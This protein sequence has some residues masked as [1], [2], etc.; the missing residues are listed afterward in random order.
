MQNKLP[1]YIALLTFV[2]GMV[3]SYYLFPHYI[4]GQTHVVKDVVV[5][6]DTLI[7]EIHHEPIYIVEAKADTVLITNHDTLI[8]VK[9]F[10]ASLDTIVG[11]DTAHV[12]FA[13]P[14]YTFSVAISRA[15][16]S[17]QIVTQTIHITNQRVTPW[18][19][20]AGCVL[21]GGALGYLAGNAK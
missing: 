10:I 3:A 8:V 6:H 13:F 19:E 21:A 18:Y 1:A 14:Q 2:A 11:R 16:D 4:K 7:R 17:V 12:D 9:P 15:P 20:Y 5:V